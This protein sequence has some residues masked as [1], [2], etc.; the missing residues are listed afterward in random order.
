[1]FDTRCSRASPGDGEVRL[2]RLEVRTGFVDEAEGLFGPENREDFA[3]SASDVV[4]IRQMNIA[5]AGQHVV[6][7]FGLRGLDDLVHQ[8][9]DEALGYPSEA[10]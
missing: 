1:M 2:E 4:S 9:L 3:E 10:R 5:R 6:D 8:D 7:A